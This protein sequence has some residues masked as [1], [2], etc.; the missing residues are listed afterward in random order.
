MHFNKEIAKGNEDLIRL[1]Q[2]WIKTYY[3]R[4]PDED[5]MA[6]SWYE[7]EIETHTFDE[8]TDHIILM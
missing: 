7:Y 6:G 2:K 5:D 3:L 4:Y 1:L 8:S